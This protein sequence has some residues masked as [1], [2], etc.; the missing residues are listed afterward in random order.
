MDGTLRRPGD[1][2]RPVLIEV[3]R[4]ARG[5]GGS[6]KQTYHR[7]RT[8][9]G[10]RG[11]GGEKSVRGECDATI[12]DS[13]AEKPP[14]GV[15]E[16]MRVGRGDRSTRH[17]FTGRV[18]GE[19][20]GSPG[21]DA[22]D[23]HPPQAGPHGPSWDRYMPPRRSTILGRPLSRHPNRAKLNRL[24]CRNRSEKRCFRGA[25]DPPPEAET[26]ETEEA[27]T[28]CGRSAVWSHDGSAVMIDARSPDARPPHVEPDPPRWQSPTKTPALTWT[29]T[30]I[31]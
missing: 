4:P 12:G 27:R 19:E 6:L 2:S 26:E 8:V 28:F 5:A 25:N 9:P 23:R 13:L 20:H 24:R 1:R 14:D 17:E 16:W 18:R 15:S 11:S 3:S 31:R 29:S 7:G 22:W 30:P 21:D 10:E